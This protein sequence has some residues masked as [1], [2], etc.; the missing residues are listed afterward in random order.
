MLKTGQYDPLQSTTKTSHT[1]DQAQSLQ[2]RESRTNLGYAASC[3]SA[4]AKASQTLPKLRLQSDL[5][6][7]HSQQ[8]SGECTQAL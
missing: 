7:R 1:R 5:H 4:E 2:G 6:R 8:T 3:R